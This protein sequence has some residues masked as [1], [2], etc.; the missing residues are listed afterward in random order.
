MGVVY[1]A[2]GSD[3]YIAI[4]VIHSD[5]A[6]DPEFRVRFAREVDL[7]QRVVS[8][9][10]PAFYGA[11]TQAAAPWLATEYV[12]GRTL[13]EHLTAHG[14]L[15]D[16]MLL[17][18]A[19]GVA[20]ALRVVHAAGIVH[21]DLKPGNVI[22]ASDG[23]RVLDFGIAR[24]VE[25]TALTRTGGLVG[26]PGW[27]AP[28]QYQGAEITSA[29]DL[30]AW[31]SLVA[32]A[33][34]GANPFGSGPPNALAYRVL[35][36]EPDLTGVPE[37][38]LPLLT[39]ALD[40]EP[41]T[42]PSAEQAVRAVH[43]VWNDSTAAP[44]AEPPAD[45]ATAVVQLLGNEW[46]EIQTT[47]PPAPPRQGRRR[48]AVLIAAG[49]AAG[50]LVLGG[51]AGAAAMFMSSAEDP[52]VA[53]GS[54]T[55]GAGT[56][57]EGAEDDTG[58]EGSEGA[59]DSEDTADDEGAEDEAEDEPVELP[60]YAVDYVSTGGG[61]ANTG[62]V[63]ETGDTARVELRYSEGFATTVMELSDVTSTGDGVQ[64][65]ARLFQD[66]A[67]A[68]SY[69]DLSSSWFFV[70]DSDEGYIPNSADS[71]VYQAA[72][73]EHSETFTLT[74]S[75]AE[76]SGVL[77]IDGSEGREGVGLPPFS[78]CYEAGAGFSTDYESCV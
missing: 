74:F 39:S 48:L 67:N 16:G 25:E 11:D 64:V 53:D 59:D 4:K 63:T 34:T 56:D 43:Y 45:D 7:A 54:E 6:A 13:R 71:F 5:H 42:R 3:G 41:A 49:V 50:V 35:R 14:P 52:Q 1:A 18:F 51:G 40:R 9:R 69:P 26:T 33:A 22:L 55:D 73:H 78:V 27:I 44:A 12:P 21:R 57:D 2:A 77:S 17:G 32:F 46:T 72:G 30:F 28:E 65:T 68:M 23:P 62:E 24:A 31:A 37:A 61:G 15:R 75:G 29:A 60:A 47:V 70:R 10:V 19:A 8:P 66:G 58:D 76:E 36:G 20:E 38:L